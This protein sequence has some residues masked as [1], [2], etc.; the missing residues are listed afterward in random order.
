MP[1]IIAGGVGKIT[2]IKDALKYEFI[3]A[4]STAHLLNFIGDS[5]KKTR[6]ICDKCGVQLAK[7]PSI[8]GNF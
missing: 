8:D 7:W 5:L 3:N 2:D 6:L 1:F 4:V